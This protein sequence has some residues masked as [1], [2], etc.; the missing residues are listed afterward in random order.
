MNV[1]NGSAMTG[2]VLIKLDVTSPQLLK[3]LEDVVKARPEGPARLSNGS[4][5]PHLLIMELDAARPE[6]T[7]ARVQALR[8]SAPHV[9]VCLTAERLD[10]EVLIGAVRHGVKEFLPQPIT[11]DVLDQAVQRYQERAAGAFPEQPI[12]KGKLMTVLGAKG[13]LG[14]S[15]VAVGLGTSLQMSEDRK[16]VVLVDLNPQDPDLALLLDLDP[17]H[18]FQDI[19]KDLSRLDTLF[20]M[21]IL[22]KH[23]SGMYLLPRDGR[24]AATSELIPEC[25]ERTLRMLQQLFDYVIVDCGHVL[26]PCTTTAL[27]LSPSILLVSSLHVPAIRSTKA[28]LERLQGIGIGGEKI[29]LVMTRYDANVDGVLKNAEEVL[30]HKVFWLLPNDFEAATSAVNSGQPVATVAPRSNISQSYHRLADSFSEGARKDKTS[31]LGGCVNFVKNKWA[32]DKP[33]LA[34]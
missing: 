34:S 28:L 2:S 24:E 13:G 33:A 6:H 32:K 16:S 21:N 9:D 26:D 18:V 29:R 31:M 14:A 12:K 22:S 10:T 23:P 5:T 11:R 27:D 20:L 25:V 30:H 8:K 17:T 15:S 3:T 19:A 7:F 1:E 4:A